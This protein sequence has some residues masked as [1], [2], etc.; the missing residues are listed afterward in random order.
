MP[1]TS[2]S[3]GGTHPAAQASVASTPAL[4]CGSDQPDLAALPDLDA[5]ILEKVRKLGRFPK[6]C[7]K[8]K[9]EEE[10]E[11]QRLAQR[12]RKNRSDLLSTTREELDA[13]KSPENK[14]EAL[15]KEV[16]KF[17]RWPVQHAPSKDPGRE[18]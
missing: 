16:R 9:N 18:A 2:N 17:G 1:S 15:M 7:S 13:L 4:C 11:E 10:K 8:P 5:G 6:E 3:S 12:I 14:M